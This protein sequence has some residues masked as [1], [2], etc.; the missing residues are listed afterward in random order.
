MAYTAL[1]EL[2]RQYVLEAR[3]APKWDEGSTQQRVVDDAERLLEDNGIEL[4]RRGSMNTAWLGSGSYSLV[5]EV[6]WNGKRAAAKIC[7]NIEATTYRRFAAVRAAVPA[8]VKAAL[9]EIYEI[10]DVKAPNGTTVDEMYPA[11]SFKLNEPESL[12]IVVCEYLRPTTLDVRAYYFGEANKKTIEQNADLLKRD[13]NKLSDAAFHAFKRAGI[14][15]SI[16]DDAMPG[17]DNEAE[18]ATLIDAITAY[19][20]EDDFVFSWRLRSTALGAINRIVVGYELR[21]EEKRTIVNYF[22]QHLRG[23]LFPESA[24]HYNALKRSAKRSSTPKTKALNKFIQALEWLRKHKDI[25]WY[26]L[27]ADNVMVRPGTNEFVAADIGLFG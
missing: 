20:T 6:L 12:R 13:R 1:A 2:I 8:A 24:E 5:L 16:V 7:N 18:W 19:I 3:S 15:P 17:N 10:I 11:V 26:D 25:S 22:S 27:H 9:P 21:D 23:D 14:K 4:L